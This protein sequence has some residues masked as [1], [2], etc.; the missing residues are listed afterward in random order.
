M[1]KLD[2]EMFTHSNVWEASSSEILFCLSSKMD[3]LDHAIFTHSNVWEAD[4]CR[5][6]FCLSTK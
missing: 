1:D 6:L 2:H 4:F 5:D 3:K